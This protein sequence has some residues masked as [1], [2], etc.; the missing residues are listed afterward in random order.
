MLISYLIYIV[1]NN[2]GNDNEWLIQPKIND[3]SNSLL[4]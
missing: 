1:P 2:R 4:V 3:S